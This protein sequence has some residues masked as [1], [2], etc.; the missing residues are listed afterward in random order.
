MQPNLQKICRSFLV[1]NDSGL[2]ARPCAL[3]V[4]TLKAFKSKVTVEA[5]GDQASGDSVVGL[6][7]LGAVCGSTVAFTVTG[8]D[9]TQ[10]LEAVAHLFDSGFA[11]AY[12]PKL[13]LGTGAG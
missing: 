6:M 13:N 5:N 2:H 11:E 9:A 12:D 1:K 10:V 8:E 3:L 7:M 4:N